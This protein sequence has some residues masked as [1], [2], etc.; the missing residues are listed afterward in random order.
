MLKKRKNFI[1]SVLPIKNIY[2]RTYC[3][4][5]NLFRIIN[6]KKAKKKNEIHTLLI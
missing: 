4:I 3:Y 1:L 2:S 5:Q 6:K